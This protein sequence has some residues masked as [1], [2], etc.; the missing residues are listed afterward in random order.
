MVHLATPFPADILPVLALNEGMGTF[1]MPDGSE[2]LRGKLKESYDLQIVGTLLNRYASIQRTFSS[3]LDPLFMLGLDDW[4]MA[5]FPDLYDNLVHDDIL[6]RREGLGSAEIEKLQG[7]GE[8]V[9]RLCALLAAS[10]RASPTPFFLLSSPHSQI[11]GC[12]RGRVWSGKIS[13]G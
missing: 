10:R 13:S 1:P 2:P 6:L 9:R 12:R 5:V 7:N 3:Q 11:S 4:R 8:K